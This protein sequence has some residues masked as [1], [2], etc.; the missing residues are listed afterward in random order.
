MFVLNTQKNTVRWLHTKIIKKLHLWKN[1]IFYPIAHQYFQIK[2]DDIIRKFKCI[3]N[4]NI[5]IYYFFKITM[6]VNS[7]VTHKLVFLTAPSFPVNPKQ[8]F[9]MNLAQQDAPATGLHR[10]D[11]TAKTT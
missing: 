4:N 11:E 5:Y 3:N 8:T 9:L 10:K 7:R 2:K 1:N 6:L